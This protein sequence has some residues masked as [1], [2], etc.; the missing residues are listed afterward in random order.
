MALF[1][2]I[3]LSL[4]NFNNYTKSIKLFSSLQNVNS[5]K[6]VHYNQT[7]SSQK[8]YGSNTVQSIRNYA[9]KTTFFGMFTKGKNRSE[10][11]LAALSTLNEIYM[12]VYFMIY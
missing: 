9:E 10:L 8:K 4:K 2:N 1:A 7:N 3:T 12:K 5:L 11:N 6:F